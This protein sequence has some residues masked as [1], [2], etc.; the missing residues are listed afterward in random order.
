MRK[1]KKKRKTIKQNKKNSIYFS[2][3]SVNEK[4]INCCNDMEFC[5]KDHEN[6]A[7]LLSNLL[8]L[9]TINRN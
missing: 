8:D 6:L 1:Q 7:I 9:L 2:F 4:F 5:M 3:P